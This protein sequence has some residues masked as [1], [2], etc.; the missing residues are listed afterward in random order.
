MLCMVSYSHRLK[1]GQITYYLYRT[2]DVLPTNTHDL[3]DNYRDR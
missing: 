2:F 1:S 3:L